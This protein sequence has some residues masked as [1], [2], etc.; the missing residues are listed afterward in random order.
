MQISGRALRVRILIGESD[1]LGRKALYMAIL[2]RLKA[3]GAA[4]ATVLRGLAGFGAHSRIYTATIERLSVDLPVLIEWVDRPD[5]VERILPLIEP[6]VQEGLITVDEVQVRKYAHR[7]LQSPPEDITVDQVMT[8]EV[9]TVSPATPLAD[10]VH[11]LVNQVYRAVPVVDEQHHLQGLITDGDLLQRA[12]VPRA[13]QQRA[14]TAEAFQQLLADLRARGQTAADI[15]TRE[16]VTLPPHASLVEAMRL[17]AEKGLKRLPVVDEENRLLGI[18]S[19]IDVLRSVGQRP[20][21]METRTALPPT[22]ARQVA[23][24]MLRDVPTVF[25]ETP[26]PEVVDALLAAQQRRAVVVDQDRRV[27]GIITDG[28]LISRASEAEAP[29]VL[30]RL[31]GATSTRA[32]VGWH[33]SGRRTRAA[34]V[35]TPHPVCVRADATPAEALALVLAHGVKRLP[36]V[37]EQGRLVGLVGRAGLMRALLPA[38]AS[39]STAVTSSSPE[40]GDEAAP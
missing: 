34:D 26:L 30:A 12:G 1:R 32:P 24:V 19:R 18:I 17:M 4:G 10:V 5:R 15:M 38:V 25:P 37:D 2:E 11:L 9:G 29:G 22:G 20:A 13:A 28:D 33:W 14:L 6:M 27:L 40:E 36:V 3:E 39:E 35:M 21:I 8:R 7:A 16:L 31:Q 23:D